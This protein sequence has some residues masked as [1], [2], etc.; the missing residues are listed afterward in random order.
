[1]KLFFAIIGCFLF[2]GLVFAITSVLQ[3]QFDSGYQH[4]LLETKPSDF[5]RFPLVCKGS[6]PNDVRIAQAELCRHGIDVKIDGDCGKQTA[7]GI[8]ELLVK[9]E[10]GYKVRT[11][12][13]GRTLK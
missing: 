10:N 7:L 9:I 5:L 11:I 13:E 3:K 4:G 6:D 12:Y 2:I 8:C 1:M